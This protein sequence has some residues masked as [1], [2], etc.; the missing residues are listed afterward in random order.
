MPCLLSL[1]SFPFVTFIRLNW[2]GDW[3]EHLNQMWPSLKGKNVSLQCQIIPHVTARAITRTT[4][5]V[6]SL[7]ECIAL[8]QTLCSWGLAQLLPDSQLAVVSLVWTWSGTVNCFRSSKDQIRSIGLLFHLDGII[9]CAVQYRVWRFLHD[10]KDL[11]G[12]STATLMQD[13]FC[14]DWS[15]YPFA[16]LTV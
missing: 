13:Q 4:S 6:V 3:Q 9:T 5:G 15:W 1:F 8:L 2:A 11:Q 16:P 12:S 10:F 14:E 7:C